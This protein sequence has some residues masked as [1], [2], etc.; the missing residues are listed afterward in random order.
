MKFNHQRMSVVGNR[1]T[2]WDVLLF[3]QRLALST[4]KALH[5]SAR[6][7]SLSCLR[8]TIDLSPGTMTFQLSLAAIFRVS[9]SLP[10]FGTAIHLS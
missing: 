5:P 9:V 4:H 3:D 2:G 1:H 8:L 10:A 7:P 6:K